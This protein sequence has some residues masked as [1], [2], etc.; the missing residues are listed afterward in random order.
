MELLVPVIALGGLYLSTRKKEGFLPNTNLPDKNYPDE[1]VVSTDTELTSR[2]STI[3]KFDAKNVYTDKY[4]TP[5]TPKI[6][7]GASFQSMTGQNVGGD[8]FEHNNMVPFF[9]AKNRSV[10]QD[11]NVAESVL[12]NYTGSGTHFVTKKEQSPMFTPGEH[13]QYANGSPNQND[14]YQSRVNPSLRMANVKPFQEQQVGPG[15][16]LGYTNEGSG[17]YNSGMAMRDAWM[18][19][20][21]DQMRTDNHQR[22]SGIGLFGHEGPAISSIKSLGSIGQ[23]EKNRVTRTFE[24]GPERYF[25]TTGVEKAPPSRAIP[26]E[27]YVTRPETT[28]SYVGVA[29]AHSEM[30]ASG[31]YMKSKRMELGPTQMGIVKGT[32]QATTADFEMQAKR[33]YPNNRSQSQDTYFGAFSS[34][35]G[36]VIAP[37]L[38]ELRPSRKQ[39]VI[40]N[41][42][43]YENAHTRISSSYLFNP[44]DRT[45]TTIRETT[46]QNKFIAGINANQHGGG[47]ATTEYQPIKNQRDTTTDV[48]YAGG[49]S[50]GSKLRPVDAEYRQRNND[51]KSSTIQGHMVP[52]N[53]KLMNS[54]IYMRNREG[55][56]ANKRALVR[57][58]QPQV[59]STDTFGETSSKQGLYSSIQTDRT[60]PDILN[61]FRQNPYT[62][63]LTDIA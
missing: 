23:V 57:T 5:S 52:G 42:R 31:E 24:T 9:G 22:A 17:G 15:L 51:I 58:G 13:L 12:D 30:Y 8:Y 16:G 26:V 14:F 18:D 6:A 19:K 47:Y 37:L 25:T 62:H 7:T 55:E 60:N 48:F 35:I 53:M 20:N 56:S 46:E 39:N 36:A 33:A 63:S 59:A 1:A 21:V 38:D 50:E 32:N 11:S 61:A 10:I 29:G 49:A 28:A 44:A 4:F 2:L 43:P 41:L 45:P 3:N 34:A 40:G 54:D 27:K